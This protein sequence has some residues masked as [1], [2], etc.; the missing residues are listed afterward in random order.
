MST[1]NSWQNVK[2]MN[3]EAGQ[4]VVQLQ[5]IHNGAKEQK[6]EAL[7]EAETA[8]FDELTAKLGTLRSQIRSATV[9]AAVADQAAILAGLGRQDIG[10]SDKIGLESTMYRDAFN[11]FIRTGEMTR[12]TNTVISTT[13]NGAYVPKTIAP[14]TGPAQLGNSIMSAAAVFGIQ[15]TPV[16]GAMQVSLPV[17]ALADGGALTG[18]EDTEKLNSSTD[19]SILVTV[20]AH[21]S[22]CQWLDKGIVG[23]QGYDASAALVPLLR[24]S[25]ERGMEARWFAAHITTDTLKTAAIAN[26]AVDAAGDPQLTAK[27]MSNLRFELGAYAFGRVAYFAS[28]SAFSQLTNLTTSAGFPDNRLQLGPDGIYRFDGYPIFPTT[29]LG[30]VADGEFPLA[31]VNMDAVAIAQS[32][33]MVERYENHPGRVNQ[34]GADYIAYAGM[35]IKSGG[36]ALLGTSAGSAA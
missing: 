24:M 30:T 28:V 25:C 6:R 23:A 32:N 12:A 2:A 19:A 3:E 33:G 31:V 17:L 14:L 16:S 22:G 20:T 15:P 13:G 7:D 34:V 26:E 9:D 18:S 27:D 4:I 21:N 11:E 8:K 10:Q 36:V 35:A 5:A 1:K 29:A